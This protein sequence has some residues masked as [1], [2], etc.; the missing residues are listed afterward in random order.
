[1]L[2]LYF[3]AHIIKYLSEKELETKNACQKS[4]LMVPL[5][6][7]YHIV[8]N[9]INDELFFLDVLHNAKDVKFTIC[10]I[11]FLSAYIYIY[12]VLTPIEN[13]HIQFLSNFRT[14]FTKTGIEENNGRNSKVD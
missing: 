8:E 5:I 10:S 12:S 9:F 1:M 3:Y 11:L 6:N 2:K 14:I 13:K 4:I 7:S